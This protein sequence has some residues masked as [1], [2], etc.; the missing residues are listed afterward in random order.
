MR[1]V[2]VFGALLASGGLFF[3]GGLQMF[4]LESGPT[5]S[6]QSVVTIETDN[7][8]CTGFIVGRDLIATAGHCV[9]LPAK[10]STVLFP[11]DIRVPYKVL[12]YESPDPGEA[13]WALLMADTGTRPVYRLNALLPYPGESITHIGHPNATRAQYSVFGFVLGS[14]GT[15][16]SLGTT[17]V[18]GESGSP[19]LNNEGQVVGIITRTCCPFPIALASDVHPLKQFLDALTGGL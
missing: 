11:D 1:S 6:F 4:S 10:S 8:V 9:I 17:A 13:D 5:Q 12:A 15:T 16:I 19:V 18:G 3:A 2:L 7:Y 14:S